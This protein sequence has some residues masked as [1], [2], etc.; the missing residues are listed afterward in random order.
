MHHRFIFTIMFFCLP[1]YHLHAADAVKKDIPNYVHIYHIQKPKDG[2]FTQFF[3]Y[4]ELTSPLRFFRLHGT[5]ELVDLICSDPPTKDDVFSKQASIGV[6][7]PRFYDT[8]VIIHRKYFDKIKKN[9]LKKSRDSLNVKD[10]ADIYRIKFDWLGSIARDD[11][12]ENRINIYPRNIWQYYNDIDKNCTYRSKQE[13]IQ[14]L[15]QLLNELDI[16]T[17]FL[18]VD[19]DKIRSLL[20]NQQLNTL[21]LLQKHKGE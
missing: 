13:K 19:S 21:Q 17:D 14:L 1:M 4:R 18:V 9:Y 8:R 5:Q 16:Q 12:K 15:I 3:Y 7:I 20:E 6:L 10:L 2:E 11:P